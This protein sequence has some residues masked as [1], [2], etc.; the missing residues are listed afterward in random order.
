MA[1]I[2]EHFPMS[3]NRFHPDLYFDYKEWIDVIVMAKDG[4]NVL[5]HEIIDSLIVMN[6][7]IVSEL[8]VLYNY[9][10][11]TG[12]L[13]YDD[14]CMANEG[15][16][17]NEYLKLFTNLEV[18]VKNQLEKEKSSGDAQSAVEHIRREFINTF[19][20]G[21]N[22]RMPVNFG[23]IFVNVTT[24]TRNHSILSAQAMRISFDLR[25]DSTQLGQH[26]VHY[27][28]YR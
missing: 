26:V 22:G 15:C 13:R 23:N 12:E 8:S 4:G 14:L 10:G 21:Y 7:Y 27:A 6:E 20:I 1:N 11:R 28:T 25:Q 9:S 18:T 3:A 2:N 24:D 16:F 17:K 5:R 19:P